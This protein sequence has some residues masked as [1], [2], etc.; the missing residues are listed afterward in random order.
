MVDAKREQRLLQQLENHSGKG[1]KE[2]ASA[3]TL[4]ALIKGLVE[5]AKEDD[6]RTRIQRIY[7]RLD[8]DQSG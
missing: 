2:L 7:S 5:V 3:G 1:R 6:V 4:D 8:T